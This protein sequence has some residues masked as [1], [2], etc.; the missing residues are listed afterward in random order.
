MRHACHRRTLATAAP[1]PGSRPLDGC[2]PVFCD[3]TACSDNRKG[4][5][6]RH[7]QANWSVGARG[8]A[9]GRRHRRRLCRMVSFRS[10]LEIALDSHHPCLFVLLQVR[11]PCSPSAGHSTRFSGFSTGL[12]TVSVSGLRLWRAALFQEAAGDYGYIRI[13]LHSMVCNFLPRASLS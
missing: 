3:Q 13:L 8:R 1:L 11:G 10:S 9:H 6:T 7:Q 12:R 2:S 5:C 4:S